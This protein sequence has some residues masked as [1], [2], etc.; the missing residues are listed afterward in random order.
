MTLCKY[1]SR[2][3]STELKN[4]TYVGSMKIIAIYLRDQLEPM[5]EG[6]PTDSEV[7]GDDFE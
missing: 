7:D 5:M 3:E 4:M 6:Q 1:L 2:P